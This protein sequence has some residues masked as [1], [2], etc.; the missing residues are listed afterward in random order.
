[1]KLLLGLLL[2]ALLIGGSVG[3]YPAPFRFSDLQAPP[4]VMPE[5]H[6]VNIS[7]LN[8]T[9]P[10]FEPEI[11]VSPVEIE[12]EPEAELEPEPYKSS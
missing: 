6:S 1:M 4:I 8:I 7:H 9:F 11:G 3:A 10:E 2:L 12:L 5:L